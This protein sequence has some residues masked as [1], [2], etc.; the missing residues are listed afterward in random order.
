MEAAS[1]NHISTG[2]DTILQLIRHRRVQLVL[3][4]IT[5]SGGKPRAHEGTEILDGFEIRRAA[6]ETGI[7]CLTSLDTA[8]AVVEALQDSSN[9]H[10]LPIGEY[11]HQ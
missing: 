7:P 9:Y 5:G 3:N 10:V 2:D 11:R 1:V 4:T 8:R 6:V